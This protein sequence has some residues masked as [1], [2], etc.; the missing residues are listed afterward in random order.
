MK[1]VHRPPADDKKIHSK[2]EFELCYIRH[3]YFR[4]VAYNPTEEQMKPYMKIIEY[5]A[6]NTFYTYRYLFSAIGMELEDITNIGRVHLVNFIGLFEIGQDKNVEKY[7]E[8]LKAF[9]RKNVDLPCAEDLVSK[10]KANLTM[11]MKQRMEDLVRICKQKAKNIRGL[12]IDEYIPFYGP[13]PPPVE[14]YR[15]LEDNE[16]YGFKRADTVM[17]K[18]LKKRLKANVKEPFT[19]AG[20]WYVAIPL[21]QRSLSILDLVGAGLDPRS[22]DHY[23][24]PERLLVERE[25]ENRL[26][27]NRKMFKNYSK[28]EKAKTIFN[29][30]EKNENNPIFQTEIVIAKRFLRKMG[31]QY[32]R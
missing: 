13:T 7:Q 9:S 2:N 26:D 11:F 17:F 5:M 25:D 1:F 20:V 22:G 15:L 21:E 6:K 10:N 23:K 29:F 16:A 24:D 3:Q 30:I 32:V 12:R 19:Y 14:L 18:A 4:R 31:I 28:E 27:K 8:F